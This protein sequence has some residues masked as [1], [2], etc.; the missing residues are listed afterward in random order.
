MYKVAEMRMFFFPDPPDA[1]LDFYGRVFGGRAGFTPVITVVYDTDGK[2]NGNGNGN[3]N[4]TDPEV[5]FACMQ[6]FERDGDPREHPYSGGSVVG[7]NGLGSLLALVLSLG[8][9]S[10]L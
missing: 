7:Q 4:D 1:G 3:D 10:A 2:G 6:T 9:A 5:Q 8:L